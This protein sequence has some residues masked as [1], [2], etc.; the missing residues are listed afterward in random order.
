MAQDL[1][2]ELVIERF[3]PESPSLKDN[4]S[5]YLI[6]E[7]TKWWKVETNS[8]RKLVKAN[9]ETYLMYSQPIE[10]SPIPQESNF[11]DVLA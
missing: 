8:G 9:V 4:I 1:D 3:G 11:T 5:T 10:F 2:N 7:V 6:K